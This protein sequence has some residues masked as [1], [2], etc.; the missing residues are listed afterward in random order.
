MTD[1]NVPSIVRLQ[2]GSIDYRYYSAKAALEKNKAFKSE[3]SKFLNV[4]DSLAQSLPAMC[5][6]VLLVLIF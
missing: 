4:S 5:T 3:V 1:E 6:V 2:D